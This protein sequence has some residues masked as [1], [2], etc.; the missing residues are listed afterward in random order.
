M[1]IWITAMFAIV[2]AL[3]GLIVWFLQKNRERKDKLLHQKQLLYESLLLSMVD[4]YSGNIAPIFVEAQLAWLYASDDLLKLLNSFFLNRAQKDKNDTELQKIIGY[5]LLEMR[6]DIIKDTKISRE[7]TDENFVA[8]TANEE[9]V[10]N[11]VNQEF[12]FFMI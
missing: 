2:S 11:I 6:E 4:L 7:W 12:I 9:L 8:L 5:I 10:A 1:E 3:S